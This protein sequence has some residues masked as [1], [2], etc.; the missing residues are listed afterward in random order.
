[1]I[2]VRLPFFASII[3]FAFPYIAKADAAKELKFDGVAYRT[4]G[5]FRRDDFF[6]IKYYPSAQTPSNP[7]KCLAFTQQPLSIDRLDHLIDLYL[8]SLDGW[9]PRAELKVVEKSEQ[10]LV[11]REIRFDGTLSGRPFFVL[12]IWELEGYTFYNSRFV[13]RPSHPFDSPEAFSKEFTARAAVWLQD[14]RKTSRI[15]QQLI[16]QEANHRV[17]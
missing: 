1:M 13:F 11:L 8:K 16:A 3:A 6:H 17:G 10:H 15:V 4:E 2:R 5:I 9:K 7:A 14:L 12:H